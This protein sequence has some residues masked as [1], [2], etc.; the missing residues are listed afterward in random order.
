MK[1][2]FCYPK[3]ALPMKKFI[4]ILG[5][6]LGHMGVYF[7]LMMLVFGFVSLATVSGSVSLVL[8]WTALL[9]AGLT[10]LCDFLFRIAS[11]SLF[12]KIVLHGI[13]TTA[14]F[15]FAVGASGVLERGKT[16]VFGVILFV[17]CYVI[18][19]TIGSVFHIVLEKKDSSRQ[20]YQNIYAPKN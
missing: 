20:A 8:I 15:A 17:I 13:L 9:F 1:S 4:S 16:L 18:V 19:A 5:S 2:V 7:M 14:S 12:V 11:M 3:G 6:Y 10:A